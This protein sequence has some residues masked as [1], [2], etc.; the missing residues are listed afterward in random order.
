MEGTVEEPAA[1][2]SAPAPQAPPA[3]AEGGETAVWPRLLN[4]YKSRL[5][6]MRRAFLDSAYGVLEG[7]LL[8]VICASDLTRTQ[9]HNEEVQSVLQE[10]T[11]AAEGR[12]ISVTFTVGRLPAAPAAAG[13]PQED[14]LDALIGLGSQF[15]NFKV[16]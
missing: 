2:A 16:K 5:P 7:D 6:A 11:S 15:D 1:P 8:K 12:P 14:K 13:A 10:I 3:P 4:S 9:L